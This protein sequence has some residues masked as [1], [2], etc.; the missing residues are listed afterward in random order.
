MTN[1]QSSLPS[2]WDCREGKGGVLKSGVAGQLLKL[3]HILFA[4]LKSREV[5]DPS[6]KMIPHSKAGQGSLNPWLSCWSLRFPLFHMQSWTCSHR[7]CTKILCLHSRREGGECGVWGGKEFLH[8]LIFGTWL[9]LAPGSCWIPPGAESGS[10]NSFVVWFLTRDWLI[11]G[12]E[13][14]GGSP[15]WSLWAQ[16]KSKVGIQLQRKDFTFA[17]PVSCTPSPGLL[18]HQECWGSCYSHC[19]I[20]VFSVYTLSSMVLPERLSA[21][22]SW[23]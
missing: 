1:A 21:D 14:E 18:Q 10:T 23:C 17:N 16:M 20:K 4:L 22:S 11:C 19:R 8:H 9:C 5:S 2:P 3:L 12:S 6:R 13:L 7:H 15:A